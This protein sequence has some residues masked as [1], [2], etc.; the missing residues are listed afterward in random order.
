MHLLPSKGSGNKDF[1]T[2]TVIDSHLAK[3]SIG[4]GKKREGR[5]AD[6]D[7]ILNSEEKRGKKS[8][9]QNQA[10]LMNGTKDHPISTWLGDT[11]LTAAIQENKEKGKKPEFWIYAYR[12][13]GLKFIHWMRWALLPLQMQNGGETALEH[14]SLITLSVKK[15]LLHKIIASLLKLEAA[16]L[17][18][19]RWFQPKLF[20]DCTRL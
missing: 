11:L 17:Q 3:Y 1:L 6:G 19:I 7:C 2:A 20:H 4:E 16:S 9:F 5:R 12:K 13:L 14:K 15:F 8:D 10:G 18:S